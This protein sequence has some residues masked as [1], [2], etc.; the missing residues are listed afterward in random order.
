MLYE[1]RPDDTDLITFNKEY[2]KKE[3]EDYN[4]NFKDKDG[5]V[6]MQ[7]NKKPLRI[8]GIHTFGKLITNR[9]VICTRYPYL[10]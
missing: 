4:P 9:A 7:V 1:K 2:K 6:K 10:D 5:K 3:G 8:V